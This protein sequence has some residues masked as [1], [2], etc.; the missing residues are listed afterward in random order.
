MTAATHRNGRG[1][2]RGFVGR[3]DRTQLRA[4]LACIFASIVA[5]ASGTITFQAARADDLLDAGLT[6]ASRNAAPDIPFVYQGTTY[7]KT[8]RGQITPL[9]DPSPDSNS[10]AGDGP[11]TRSVA[12]PVGPESALWPAR[13]ERTRLTT[14]DVTAIKA[15]ASERPNSVNLIPWQTPIKNQ[16]GRGT[17]Y[18]FAFTAGLEA[19]YRH[20]YGTVV[21]GKYTGPQWILSEEYLIHVAKSTLLNRPQRY[22]FENP[23][24]LWSGVLGVVGFPMMI[25][26]LAD[27]LMNYRV[28]EAQYSPYLPADSSPPNSPTGLQQLASASCPA[29]GLLEKRWDGTP[30]RLT[31]AGQCSE[32][33][34]ATQQEVDACEYLPEHIPPAASRN[35]RFGIAF[36]F[37]A[38][39]G[40]IQPGSKTLTAEQTRDTD[41]LESLLFEDHEVITEFFLSWKRGPWVNASFQS[42]PI[43]T[44]DPTVK[45]GGHNMLVV[46]YDRSDPSPSHW[47]FI[48]KN[49]WGGEKYY[50]V[51][52]EFMQKATRGSV[53]ILDAAD[54]RL[55]EPVSL[56]RGGAWL[57]IWPVHRSAES[58]LDGKLV[59]RRTFDPNVPIQPRP[60]INLQLG[61]YDPADGS[62]PRALVGYLQSDATIVFQIEGEHESEESGWG[63]SEL[64]GVTYT[65]A[66]GHE[67]ERDK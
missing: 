20:K 47:Y 62:S 58:D 11:K 51:S 50:L 26:V 53:V 16:G 33:N 61:E 56:A 44:Y 65:W 8:E 41:L 13:F 35:A 42:S 12:A 27:Q 60:G 55:D 22:R 5:A 15:G 29:V 39:D 43:W 67:P 21:D 32:G 45:S 46:G 49:S 36:A 3:I 31:A 48:V 19:A 24:S 14:R 9:L 17:C 66:F 52:Y 34:C 37:R 64:R 2:T 59:I 30:P 23:S 10:G 54:P 18:V 1:Q 57:G 6:R 7:V 25:S 63:R 28:P 38:S 4:A 40:S